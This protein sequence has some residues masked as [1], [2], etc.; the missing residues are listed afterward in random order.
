MLNRAI[1]NKYR[2]S[3]H[4]RRFVHSDDKSLD[5]LST[6]SLKNSH[7]HEISV[8]NSSG[9]LSDSD[10]DRINNLAFFDYTATTKEANTKEG[11]LLDEK[12]ANVKDLFG[13]DPE[14]RAFI[15]YKLPQSL[16][17]PYIDIQLNQLKRKRLSVTQLCT[18]QNWCELRNFYDFY[19]QNWSSQLLDLKLQIQK[20][21]K[22]HKSLEDETHPE[23]NQYNSFVQ[24]FLPLTN[25]AMDIDSDMNALLDNWCSS[26]NR[27]ISLFTSGGGHSREIICHGFINFQNGKLVRD[28]SKDGNTSEE[29]VIISGIIDHLT[30]RNKRN[31]QVQKCT[32]DLDTK[33]QS[34]DSILAKL[35]SD[36]P[37]LKANNEI[38]ISDIKTRSVPK[39]PSI[40]SVVQSSKLQTMYYKFFL[41]HLSQ[42]MTQT[43][44]S[45]L[46][47]AQ[48]RGLDIDAPINSTK[49]LTFILTNPLFAN[50][51]EHLLKG[52]PINFAPFDNDTKASGIFDM[53][54]FKNLL[55]QGPTS[56]TLQTE[57]EED[58]LEP[59]KCISL[60]DYKRFYT[61][62]KTPIT[63][64]YFAAR[65]S[66]IYY[67]VGSLISNDLMIE[68]Y[69]H[70]DNFHNTIFSY[71]PVK[72]ETHAH[73]TAMVWFGH[74]DMN[75]IE[76]I[77]KKFNL[78]CK[79][80]DYKY[81]CSWKNKNELKLVDLGKEL[82]KILNMQMH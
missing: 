37:T 66:Q 11:T 36:L 78:Y 8:G 40:E 67:I 34:W 71:D 55:D 17:N 75:P 62:W 74:R 28:L 54:A 73:N 15:N 26:I 48:R 14:N 16:K 27:L 64:K 60:Q 4:L 6:F 38:V 23:L 29:N 52:K 1:T 65:L 24:D 20:G 2:F 46:I 68:Y 19:S 69:Y 22:I 3:F 77:Q 70:N 18:T 39:M 30:F 41:S 10:I 5:G 56:F 12:L 25:L 44:H 76:P 53:T 59:T 51:M 31:H 9:I 32:T 47:N 72:L 79:Y 61:K 7:T 42:D 35:L 43:Y 45:F 13:V 57:Q 50:D 81:V 63:L 82:E 58:D 80:C 33:N 21:K 49:I